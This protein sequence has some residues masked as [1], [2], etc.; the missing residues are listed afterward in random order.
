MKS[1]NYRVILL[2]MP[3]GVKGTVG[4]DPV[5]DFYTIYINGRHCQNQQL[6]TYFH[7][8][9]HIKK[10]DISKAHM[11]IGYLESMCH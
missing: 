7:E 10:D 6:L 2:D 4:Y 5:D 3:Y 8:L 1:N 9:Q 11:N